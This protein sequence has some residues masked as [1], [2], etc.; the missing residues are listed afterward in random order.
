[1][2]PKEVVKNFGN[3]PWTW[4]W[5]HEKL[6]NSQFDVND[7]EMPWL[8]FQGMNCSLRTTDFWKVGGFDEKICHWGVEDL[9]LGFRL[10]QRGV[11][12]AVGFNAW[13][14]EPPVSRD[15][16]FRLQDVKPN[17]WYFLEKH[18]EPV[19]ELFWRTLLDEGLWEMEAEYRAL[20]EW[21]DEARDLDVRREIGDALG[22]FADD[23]QRIA[24]FG[25]GA[26]LPPSLPP[27]TLVDFDRLLLDKAIA[28]R[29]HA[30]HHAIGLRTPLPDKSHDLVV[31]T[32]RLSGL[33]ERWHDDVQ[34]EAHRIG[35]RVE[36][37]AEFPSH[38]I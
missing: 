9:E 23:S 32:S 27:C 20:L 14:M 4:D 38:T 36:L 2:K 1:M 33:W 8:L 30:G 28:D 10:Q 6:T 17:A 13:A 16:E 18:P 15:M 24:I 34:A 11:P 37:T 19:S 21:I 22:G 35:R 25:C 12:F 26:G 3:E 29:R 7:R 31:I 5:R